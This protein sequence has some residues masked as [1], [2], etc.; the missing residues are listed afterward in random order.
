MRRDV[1]FDLFAGLFLLL[2]FIVALQGCARRGSV[3]DSYTKDFYE[4]PSLLPDNKIDKNPRFVVYGDNRPGWRAKEVLGKKKTW[5]TWK[6]LYLPI[7][8]QAYLLGSGVAGGVVG[9]RAGG[10]GF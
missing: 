9:R 4:I 10:G 1:S 7:V 8:Y 5:L 3:E 6:Q 2:L